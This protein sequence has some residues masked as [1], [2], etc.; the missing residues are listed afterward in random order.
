M[1][2]SLS[3]F[4]TRALILPSIL[5][6]L[7]FIPM[8]AHAQDDPKFY[9]GAALEVIGLNDFDSNESGFFES[10]GTAVI[11][12]GVTFGTYFAVEGEAAIGLTNQENDGI[13]GYNDRIAGYGRLRYPFADS[14]AEVFARLGYATSGIESN[15]ILGE[16]NQTG[17][18]YGAGV[19]YSFG[20]KDE[21]QVRLDFTRFNYGNDRNSNA[22]SLGLGYNF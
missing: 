20:S 14:G 22:A 6:V 7:C 13:A 21:F 17:L 16:G 9:V 2:N 1:F 10:A 5:S 19:A 18:T 8:Q 11:R 15:S 3:S 12:G 4:S